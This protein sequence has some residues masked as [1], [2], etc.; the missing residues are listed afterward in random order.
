MSTPGVTLV[1]GGRVLDANGE[2]EA[3]VL[4]D[5]GRIEAVGTG[6]DAPRGHRV[7]DA[8]GCLVVPGLVDL[9]T[10]F[11]PPRVMAKCSARLMAYSD[12]PICAALRMT[13]CGC[14]SR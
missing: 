2:R 7:V 6:L 5:G 3:D 14:S 4:V 9:H 13:R 10:H 1:R 8:G 12:A 11:L